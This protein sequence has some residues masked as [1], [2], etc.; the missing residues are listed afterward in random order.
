MTYKYIPCNTCK[1]R[2]TIPK[3]ITCIICKGKGNSY[4]CYT[5]YGMGYLT[6]RFLTCN[7][8]NGDGLIQ[9]EVCEI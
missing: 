7:E 6:C 3:L 4:C 5:C 1:G 9:V 2:R 8:C